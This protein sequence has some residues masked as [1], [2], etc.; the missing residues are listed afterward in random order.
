MRDMLY[1]F[2]EANRALLIEQCTALVARR[3]VPKNND[4][5]LTHGIPIF[6]DQLIKTLLTE[7][8]GGNQ[9]SELAEMA[10]LHGHD[11]F[12]QGF[13]IEQ[14]VRD[15]GDVCQSI[16]HLALET[17][18]PITVAEFRT[19]NRCLDIAI[20]GAVTEFTR[21]SAA[22]SETSFR[23]LNLRFGSVAHELRNYIHT[24]ALVIKAIKSGNVGISGATASVLD[25]SL[26]GMRNLID[27]SL[28]DARIT[29]MLPPRPKPIRLAMFLSELET[30]ASLDAQ[31]RECR[32]VVSPVG[33]DVW[34]HADPEMLSSA[35]SNLLQN[36]FQLTKAHTEVRL[37]THIVGT[38]VLIEVEDHCG[39]LPT[40]ATDPQ[41]M[42]STRTGDNRSGFDLGLDLCRRNIEANNGILR[43][44]DTPGSG[45]GF[46]IDLPHHLAA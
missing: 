5:E 12:D 18:A 43:V 16:T 13:T 3:S 7:E 15:Y 31:A 45:C 2:L 21:S 20:A 36:G 39:G 35:L 22:S 28:T 38:R 44:R 41:V 17:E 24:V 14:V 9:I 26:V 27:R 23:D 8:N 1:E 46:T 40:D 25:R 30:S 10:A 32:F 37:H 29:A 34:I 6:L 11:L 19:L 33:S 4:C 42:S